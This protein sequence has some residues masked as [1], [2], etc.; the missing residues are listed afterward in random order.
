MNIQTFPIFFF[1][2]FNVTRSE[3]RICTDGNLIEFITKKLKFKIIIS[4]FMSSFSYFVFI[5]EKVINF[6]LLKIRTVL[7]LYLMISKTTSRLPQEQI[8]YSYSWQKR[9]ENNPII[10]GNYANPWNN[11]KKKL[12]SFLSSFMVDKC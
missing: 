1:F 11:G 10:H 7:L 9:K 3:C 2:H 5:S 12:C 4:L 6:L 8:I